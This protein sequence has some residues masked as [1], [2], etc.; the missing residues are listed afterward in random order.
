MTSQEKWRSPCGEAGQ[1]SV[2]Y[3]GDED[4]QQISDKQL[5]VQISMQAR[6]ALLHAELF[7]E[8]YVSTISKSF[9]FFTTFSLIIIY[10]L[11]MYYLQTL[12]LYYLPI[13]Y[14]LLLLHTI[15]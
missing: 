3:E 4:V 1:A 13:N 10:I 9:S 12:L 15:I 7:L 11:F 6:T 5:M 14:L 2:D 8:T